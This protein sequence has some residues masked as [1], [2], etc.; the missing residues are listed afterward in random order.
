MTS[1]ME[2]ARNSIGAFITSVIAYYTF[3]HQKKKT[4]EEMRKMIKLGGHGKGF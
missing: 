2:F 3:K 1:K 4:L